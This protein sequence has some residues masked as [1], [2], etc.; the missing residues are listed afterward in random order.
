MSRLD[1]T[2]AAAGPLSG[3]VRTPLN[4][5]QIFGFWAAWAGW[6]LDGMDSRHLRAGAWPGADRTSAPFGDR[7][8]AR[9][10]RLCRLDAVRAVPGRLGPVLHLGPDRR[11]LR[12]HPDAGRHGADLLGVH[13]RRGLV[14]ERLRARRCSACSPASA[15]AANGPWPA[16]MSPKPGPR[17]GARWAPATS[18]PAIISAS[19]SPPRSTPRSARTLGWRAMFLCGLAPV[20]VSIVTLLRVKEPERWERGAGGRRPARS[21]RCARSSRHPTASA[22]S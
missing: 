5:Q 6:M 13:R 22:P 17:T 21:A 1:T 12:P 8:D 16:P 11:P 19:S 2:K 14:A 15:S 18:R 9:Q 10:C 3:R 20:V 7:G 4:R